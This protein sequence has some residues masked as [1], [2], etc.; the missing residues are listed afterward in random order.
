MTTPTDKDREKARKCIG[1]GVYYDEERER[2]AT[3]L[4]EERAP[5]LHLADRLELDAETGEYPGGH[6]AG[7]VLY[8]VAR[9][10][11][12]AVVNS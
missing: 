4:A 5:F 9:R 1:T 2:I 7:D 12:R 10:I 11:R 3:A 6:W 8:D